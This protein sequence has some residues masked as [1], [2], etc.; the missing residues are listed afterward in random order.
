VRP[1]LH[2]LY[3]SFPSARGR[4]STI[5]HA[6]ARLPRHRTLP[7]A[8]FIFE[9]H[10]AL[11]HGIV[12]GGRGPS[13]ADPSSFMLLTTKPQIRHRRWHRTGDAASLVS[14]LKTR[15]SASLLRANS[16]N[17]PAG[18]PPWRSGARKSDLRAQ[19]LLGLPHPDGE[20]SAT[21]RNLPM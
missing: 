10:C 11:C 20:G 2:S 18:N 4:S 3:D 6:Q 15:S 16:R 8:S 14:L 13:L 1:S 9:R 17:V 7:P 12:A 19:R 5:S 21:G